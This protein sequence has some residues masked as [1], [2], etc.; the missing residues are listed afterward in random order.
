M[1][2]GRGFSISY[3]TQA[4]KPIFKRSLT[5]FHKVSTFFDRN[6][7]VSK[8]PVCKLNCCLEKLS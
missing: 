6:L 4:G 3:F 5:P 1:I 8:N 2:S 7:R